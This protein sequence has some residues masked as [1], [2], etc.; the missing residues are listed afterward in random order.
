M[1]SINSWGHCNWL[2]LVMPCGSCINVC[3][4]E[5][6]LG[7]PINCTEPWWPMSV[8]T[9]SPACCAGLKTMNFSVQRNSTWCVGAVTVPVGAHGVQTLRFMEGPQDLR[10]WLAGC[11]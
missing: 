10:Q 7:A 3:A 1:T 8:L 6:G 9:P 4:M 11:F 5:Q 2:G